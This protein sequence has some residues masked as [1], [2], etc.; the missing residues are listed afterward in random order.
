MTIIPISDKFNDYAFSVCKKL[1]ENN[2]RVDIDTRSEKMGAK[3]RT[4]EINKVPIML[5]VGEKEMEENT[6]SIRRKFSGNE[7]SLKLN[8]F[9]SDI[10]KEISSRKHNIIK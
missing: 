3:I 4:A 1:K 5:I 2:L 8:D 7:G 10:T 6:I 9:I